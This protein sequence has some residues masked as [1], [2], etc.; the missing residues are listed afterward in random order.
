MKRLIAYR[1]YLLLFITVS[2]T[3]KA[4]IEN[5]LKKENLKGDVAGIINV[6][7]KAELKFGEPKKGELV[8]DLQNSNWIKTYNQAGNIVED[9]RLFGVQKYFSFKHFYND[10][11][12]LVNVDHLNVMDQLTERTKYKYDSEGKVLNEDHY[13]GD[14]TYSL[15]LD[16]FYDKNNQLIKITPNYPIVNKNHLN[17]TIIYEYSGDSIKIER[18]N[19]GWSKAYTKFKYGKK[20]EWNP[21]NDLRKYTYNSNGD[22]ETETVGDPPTRVILIY[23]Y[24]YDS[25]GNWISLI[26]Y[27]KPD[28]PNYNKSFPEKMVYRTIHYR[29][30]DKELSGNEILEESPYWKDFQESEKLKLQLKNCN[31]SVVKEKIIANFNDKITD[32]KVLE[33]SIKISDQ[34]NCSY[35]IILILQNKT[36]SY[37]RKKIE[38]T[39]LYLDD[40]SGFKASDWSEMN[41]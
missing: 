11:G 19:Y 30:P 7:Y 15:T 24:E 10:S 41:I 23:K 31:E 16:Y 6:E 25:I 4:E 20:I 22:I 37:I 33:K 35:R 1:F 2:C 26:K 13:K 18:S 8:V 9:I 39:F 38:F 21:G 29:K 28:I 3:E 12:R 36:F 5:D 27:F 40:Y 17:D 34:G 32:W 14:G